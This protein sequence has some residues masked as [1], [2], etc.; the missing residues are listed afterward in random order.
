MY[1]C[2]DIHQRIVFGGGKEMHSQSKTND[3]SFSLSF[4]I[5]EKTTVDKWS[6]VL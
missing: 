4:V 2:A 6:C 1:L 3:Y 5:S